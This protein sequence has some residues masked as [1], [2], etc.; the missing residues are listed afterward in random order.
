MSP[1]YYITSWTSTG[2]I[3]GTGSTPDGTIP[4]GAIVCTQEQAQNTSQYVVDTST[5]P[6]SVTPAPTSV[7]VKKAQSSQIAT[8]R[9]ACATAEQAPITLTLSSGTSATFGMTP[10][11]WTKIVGLYSKYVAKGAA[12]PSGYAIPDVN[13]VMQTITVTDIENLM[14]AGEAQINGALTKLSGLVAQVE[15]A[16]TVSDVQAIVW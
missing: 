6:P 5:T 7:L 13:G 14:N 12:L 16:T 11:D 2:I 1:T 4:T 9:A 3:T 10:H 15:A 8:L